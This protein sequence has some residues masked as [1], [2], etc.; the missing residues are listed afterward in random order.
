MGNI[1]PIYE[2]LSNCY[3]SNT[4]SLH[5]T[6]THI[7]KLIFA[8]E[9]WNI[10]WYGYFIYKDSLKKCVYVT[11]VKVRITEFLDLNLYLKQF[12][13]LGECSNSFLFW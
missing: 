7:N 8:E 4:F 13:G 5:Y 10:L 2:T 11:E 12:E 6:E 3:C 9:N 1:F